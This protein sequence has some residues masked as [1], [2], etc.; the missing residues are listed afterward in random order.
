[1]SKEI[2]EDT[3]HIHKDLEESILID[4]FLTVGLSADILKKLLDEIESHNKDDF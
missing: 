2:N 1:M 3:A 4:F